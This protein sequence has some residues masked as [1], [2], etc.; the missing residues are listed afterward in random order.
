VTVAVAAVDLGAT[1]V[2]VCRATLD[3]SGVSLDVVHRFGHHP[4][5]DAAGTLRWDWPRILDAVHTGLD[6]AIG[7]GP[8]ASIGVDTWGVDYGLLD[9]HGNL[10]G[11][12]VSYRDERTLD[13]RAVIERVGAR[14]LYEISG[15]QETAINTIFQVA[16]H[17]RAE[18]ADAAHLLLLPELVVH[19]LTGAIVAERTSAGTTGLVDLTTGRWSPELLDAVDLDERVLAEIS[20]PRTPCGTYRGIPVH[21]VGG[22]DTASAVVAGGRD[23]AAFLSTGTWLLAGAELP[24]PDTSPAARAAGFANEQGTFG[25]IRFLRNVAGWWLLEGCRRVWKAGSV[26]ELVDAA[27]AAPPPTIVFDATDER[28][29]APA[30]MPD[31]IRDAA[32]LG[33]D[34]T[35]P[36]IVRAALEA[37]AA[38]VARVIA[39]LPG[40]AEVRAFGGGAQAPFFLELLAGYTTLPVTHGP[41]EAT[42]LGNALTQGVALG[43]YASQSEA[44]AALDHPEPE[45]QAVLA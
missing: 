43:R 44:R 12:P 5:R 27:R 7:A 22:H 42:A 39:Q 29:L 37:M 6:C 35:H 28:F 45:R 1:S 10:V 15:L 34:A 8:L 26:A 30:S 31:E 21:L 41:A 11:S 9:R 38:T 2:R 36:E 18:L 13:Y 24:V 19:E 25:S 16:A 40:C 14:R 33:S 20:E 32:G 17:D 3:D 23:G 4:V